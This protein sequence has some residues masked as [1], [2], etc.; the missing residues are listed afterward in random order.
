MTF[1]QGVPLS[2]TVTAESPIVD[3]KS[4]GTA[5]NFTQAAFLRRY[6]F[7]AAILVRFGFY[8]VWHVLYIH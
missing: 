3:A 1:S 5:T 7:L 6:G 8:V 2:V 4:T